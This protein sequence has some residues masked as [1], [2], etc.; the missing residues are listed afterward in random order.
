[1]RI[2]IVYNYTFGI[3]L[4]RGHEMYWSNKKFCGMFLSF[5]TFLFL[6]TGCGAGGGG[7]S[8][9][10][11]NNPTADSIPPSIPT[12]LVATAV[13]SNQ[14]N[15]TW[16]VS[17]DNN[18]V[19][20]YKIYSGS[21]YLTS[22]TTTSS[23]DTG[24]NPSTQYC[25][26]VSAFDAAGNESPQSSVKCVTT[27]TAPS[28]KGNISGKL[29]VGPSL[30]QAPK[31]L[32]KT[33]VTEDSE[34]QQAEFVIGKVIVKFVETITS[35]EGVIKL[36]EIF[37]DDNLQVSSEI[38]VIN[39]AVLRANIY[40]AYKKGTLSKEDGRQ[41][42]LDLIQQIQ[43]LPFIEYAE[44][45]Y[46]RS[47]QA[48]PNDPGYPQ[49]WH[50]KTI[51]LPQAWDD[52]I[53]KGNNEVIV[54]VL[55]D[56]IRRN[57]PDLE[58]NILDTGYDFISDLQSAADGNGQ[59]TDPSAPA[60]TFICG[61]HYSNTIHGTHVAGT[62]AA[63]YNNRIGVTGVAWKSKI[64]PVRVLG[65]CGGAEE[66]IQQGLLYA[67]GL[68]NSSGK[69]PLQKAKVVNM[70]LGGPSPNASTQAIINQ[71]VTQGVTV[72]AAAG[73][74]AVNNKWDPKNPNP[75][76]YPCAY[77]NVICVGAASPSLFSGLER[78]P[79]S[80][81][82]AYVDIVAPGGNLESIFSKSGVLSTAWDDNYNQ[83]DYKSLQGTSMATPHVS[84][85]AA[86]MLSVNPFL[87][88][89][90]IEQILKDTAYDL[91]PPGRDDKYG[92][93]LINAY[94]AV[95]YGN[96][97]INPVLQTQP[98]VLYFTS[99]DLQGNISILNIGG[100]SLTISSVTN[101]EK[102]GGNWLT[103]SVDK[104]IVPAT[105]TATV[106]SSGLSPGV[107]KATITINYITN[108]AGVEK[109]PVVF[110]NRTTP[111][112]GTVI[113]RLVDNQGNLVTQT[114]TSKVQSY[115]YQFTDLAP[116]SYFVIAGTDQ[117]GSGAPDNWGEFIGTFPMLGDYS[118]VTVEAGKTASGID[119]SLQDIG[120][121]IYFDGNGLGPIS[122]A[123]LVNVVDETGEPVEGA[124]VYI[125]NGSFSGTTNPFGRTTILGNFNGPQTV[126]ATA[127]GYSTSTYYQTNAS[128]LTF[129][130][131]RTVPPT[132]TLTVTL[133]GLS[134]GEYGCVWI[135]IDN[136][137]CATY[138]G[139]NPN[140]YFTVP[141]DTPLTLSAIG[142]NAIYGT[143]VKVDY[144]LLSEGIN[145]YSSVTLNMDIPPNWHYFQAWV[146][147]P[148]GNF[149][150]TSVMGW[151]GYSY[152][153]QGLYHDPIIT[154]W[155]DNSSFTSHLLADKWFDI[156]V[157]KTTP[158][159]NAL[160][161]SVENAYGERT[162]AY[163]QASFDQL[164]SSATY[165]LYDVPSLTIPWGHLV[166]SSLRP[167]FLWYNT[168]QPSIQGIII[169]DPVSGYE[170][171]IDVPGTT[172]I[173]TLPDIPT[174]GLS[175]GVTY[176]WNVVNI[177]A[178]DFDYNNF[179]MKY[180]MQNLW[181]LSLSQTEHFVTP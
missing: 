24:L 159:Y 161:V 34:E 74:E 148:S 38:S 163:A 52:Y 141:K 100:G 142:Y 11:Q 63:V 83:P 93:G 170:W 22:V 157:A 1:M 164:L 113:V 54:A 45:S 119:F 40:D 23:S 36:Q 155:R 29:L 85:V 55:D 61:D 49:Q 101:S 67:A 73:N 77:N 154:G 105:V 107:Y 14:I 91:G 95:S 78:A 87:T 18:A 25:Y 108:I 5:V 151:T 7:G 43:N 58:N 123:L 8:T 139:I 4:P 69:I 156:W 172:T 167:T 147:L 21:I 9:T 28:P 180:V 126:S 10:N 27:P 57:H 65:V 128:Y 109:I 90:Q 12:N 60:G 134:I 62:I 136:Y 98:G 48:I 31:I 165:N 106:N 112:L 115:S 84:G 26:T 17:T 122:G 42:T 178:P 39:A 75:V 76:E 110:D 177:M 32:P 173:I 103:T 6:L 47:A 153:Y 133:S 72:I 19:T 44:P 82:N 135:S 171:E 169:S 144:T 129:L 81:Y 89:A 20:G 86:L 175:S 160:G 149:D 150:K 66:D 96:L 116:G 50:Y 138:T 131:S 166:T 92:Y 80:N 130:I 125:G 104:S 51:A 132:T 46:I 94:H 88:P 33:Q 56:G 181:G 143:P 102:S 79:Y 174:G 64:M 2:A 124:K 97:L 120:D 146:N 158:E 15:L 152:A 114:T 179:D 16:S 117:D 162:V 13:S 70:S 99:A 176:D 53:A 118:T 127:P 168:F 30:S 41:M 59:D 140:L 35:A 137:D 121:L 37:N 145:T 68:P 111:D 3:T 71:V